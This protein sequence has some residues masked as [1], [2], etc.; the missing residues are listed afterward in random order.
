MIEESRSPIHAVVEQFVREELSQE[1]AHIA[2]AVWSMLDAGGKRLRPRITM[3]AGRAVNA[4][5]PDDPVLASYMELIH[6][7]TLIHDD[8]LDNADTRRGRESTNRAFGNRFSVLAGDY[9]FSWVFKK[10]TLGY[11]PPVPTILAAMLAEICNGEVKQLRAAGD[12]AMTPQRYLEIIGKKTAELFGSC[13]EVGAINALLHAGRT[14]GAALREDPQVHALR[15]F[16]RLF[17]LAFQIR[18][19]LYDAIADEKQ[20][21]KPAGSDLREK[22]MTLPLINA[23][24]NGGTQ[25]RERVEALFAFEDAGSAAARPALERVVE[26]L[27]ERSVIDQTTAPMRRYADEALAALGPLPP[28]AARDELAGMARTLSAFSS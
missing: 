22:K 6:V 16:G 11:A 1:N 14:P 10:I 27:R 3:L 2:G 26:L 7:A 5:A 25:A 4:S 21:G 15:E 13:A 17:G 20:L 23:L 28:S 24:A 18:D 19:D 8:V 9:L 12:L